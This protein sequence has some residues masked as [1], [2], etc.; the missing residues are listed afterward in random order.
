MVPLH[1]LVIG[2]GLACVAI[3]ALVGCGGG[4]A[5]GAAAERLERE[6]TADAYRFNARVYADGKPTTFKLEIYH[7][8]SV[9]G[10]YG[11]GYLGKGGLRGRATRDSLE[12]YFPNSKEYLYE[13][14]VTMIQSSACPVPIGRLNLLDIFATTPDKIE[15]DS[16][17]TVI[18][19]DEDRDEPRFIVYNEACPWQIEVT[20]RQRDNDEFRVEDFEFTDG[21][22]Y[23]MWGRLERFKA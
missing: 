19:N 18:R 13:S 14:L 10:L 12:L 20:Y 15:F 8:D 5:G 11:R 21:D 7:T 2:L 4:Y 9:V 6:I 23:R 16:S 17:I 3:V 22:K 1:R